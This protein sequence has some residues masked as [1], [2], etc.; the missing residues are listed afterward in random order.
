M[1]QKAMNA[2]RVNINGIEEPQEEGEEMELLEL[3]ELSIQMLEDIQSASKG[4]V[5]KQTAEELNLS[6]EVPFRVED[7]NMERKGPDLSAIIGIIKPA[8]EAHTTEGTKK[9]KAS[10]M[11]YW[12]S[13]CAAYNID[14][15]RFG[16]M[17]TNICIE[18]TLRA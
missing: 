9:Q 16:K 10:Y 12:G 3:P 14:I 8:M 2:I 5:R 18:P 1:S 7:L 4:A 11:N 15:Q 13:F 17:E 6:S